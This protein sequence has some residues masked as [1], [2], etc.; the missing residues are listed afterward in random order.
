MRPDSLTDCH[1]PEKQKAK[2]NLA[3]LITQRP[4]IRNGA[5]W[6]RVIVVLRD[7]KMPPPKKPQP[8]EAQRRQ[9][10]GTLHRS[11]HEFDYSSLDEP[12]FVPMRRFTHAQYDNT[13][14]DLFGVDLRR[15]PEMSSKCRHKRSCRR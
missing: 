1:G 4:L 9:L 5:D 10:V 6:E 13:I 7:E 14:R 3:R 15:R 12:G 8:S 2:I 11:I